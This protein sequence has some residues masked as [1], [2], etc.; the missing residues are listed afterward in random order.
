MTGGTGIA[1]DCY[2]AIALHLE[3]SAVLWY[4]Y[5]RL[6]ALSKI[7]SGRKNDPE[8]EVVLFQL[9]QKMQVGEAAVEPFRNLNLCQ[10]DLT[11]MRTEWTHVLET[12]VLS[13]LHSSAP[14]GPAGALKS[15]ALPHSARGKHLACD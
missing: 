3:A 9:R 1:R 5:V 8:L 15:A 11:S 2:A 14:S 4:G 7:S 13:P 10:N 12:S 6:R